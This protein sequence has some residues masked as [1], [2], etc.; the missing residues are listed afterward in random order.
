M[1][2]FLPL[3]MLA[4]GTLFIL[5]SCKDDEPAPT[6]ATF[7]GVI[8][9]ENQDLWETW[10]DSGEVQVTIFP[11]FSLDP[12]AGWGEI[13]DET[14]GP[15]VPGGTFAAGPPV[16]AQN[17]LVLEYEDG[18]TQ[19]EFEFTLSDMSG[20]VEFSAL[21]VGFRHDFIPDATLRTA[22]LGVYWNNEDEVSH[23][24]VIKP[25]IGAPPIFDYPAPET[26]V[27]RPGDNLE[28]NFI[29]DF[30]FVEEWYR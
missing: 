24:I 25:A 3:L 2:R 27:L 29:A 14:F 22:T 18:R 30:G 6:T 8:T 17:P 23:G 15:N 13:P 4:M 1:K 9:F 19:Y 26:F 16:N 7:K 20:P 10:Q 11:P 5:A 28:L 21:A 12:L